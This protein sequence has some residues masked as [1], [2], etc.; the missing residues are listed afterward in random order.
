MKIATPPLLYS[1]SVKEVL[2]PIESKTQGTFVLFRYTDAYS[3][4]D[5]GRMPDLIPGKGECLARIAAH[6]FEQLALPETWKEFSRSPGALALRR[7]AKNGAVLNEVGE[8]LQ[9]EGVRSHYRGLVDDPSVSLRSKVLGELT[10][11]TRHM[12]VR[13]VSVVSPR[14]EQVMGQPVYDYLETRQSKAPRL[15]PLEVVFRHSLPEG[16][17]LL[18]RMRA[19]GERVEAGHRFEFPSLEL[20]TKLES[21]DRLLTV[22]EAL[23]IS[24]ISA[25]LLEELLMQTAWIS[26][27]LKQEFEASGVELCDGKLEWAIDETGSLMLVDAI[28]PDELRLLKNGVQLSKEFLRTHYRSSTWF[29]ELNRVKQASGGSPDWKRSVL[30]KPEPLPESELAHASELYHALSQAICSRGVSKER[31]DRLVSSLANRNAGSGGL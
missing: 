23:A 8:R 26:A 1:G 19:R 5:W 22:H 20:F 15:I 3:V 24:G 14:A 6:F 28:G 12:L 9:R 30:S 11:P 29:A 13:A 18:D 4:F 25:S 21:T 10:D 2:G 27:W 7:A 31:L 17:S 16:S